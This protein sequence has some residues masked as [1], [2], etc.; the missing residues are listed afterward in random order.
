MEFSNSLGY[1]VYNYN[2]YVEECSQ[3]SKPSKGVNPERTGLLP[4]ASLV[5][6]NLPKAPT[7]ENNRRKPFI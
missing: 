6:C 1:V 2:K 7:L 5:I 4:L 3:T